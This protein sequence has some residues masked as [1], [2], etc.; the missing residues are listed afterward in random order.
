MKSFSLD[1]SLHL[2][3]TPAGAYFAVSSNSAEPARRLLQ[4][5]MSESV[6]PHWDHESLSE[7]SGLEH[8]EAQELL[9]RLQELGWMSGLEQART[10]PDDPL[11]KI[12]PTL[13]EQLSAEGKALLADNQGF[14]LAASGI[15]HEAA[16]S[17]SAVSADL[18][19]LF[20]RHQRLLANNLGQREQAWALTDAAGN[21]QLG[22]W[23]LHIGWQRFVLVIE[24]RPSF[25]QPAFRDLV[26]ILTLRYSN[27][28]F[29]EDEASHG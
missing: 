15:P 29:W 24:G 11:E 26:W 14:Y 23:P 6:S 17:L 10:A 1:T 3:P 18:G 19:S 8:K 25:N 12:L 7:W 21:S 27:Q 2:A 16:E 9:Y 13:L 28:R 4:G 22:F 20:E 5:V